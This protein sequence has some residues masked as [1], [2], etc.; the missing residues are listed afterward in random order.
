MI[1]NIKRNES[2]TFLQQKVNFRAIRSELSTVKKQRKR[3]FNAT[4][5]ELYLDAC[6]ESGTFL[7]QKATKAEHSV[8]LQRKVNFYSL[9]VL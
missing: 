9:C 1:P 8:F 7:G 6:N 3:N 2:G 5:S 4:E